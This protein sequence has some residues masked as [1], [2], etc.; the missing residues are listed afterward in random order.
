MNEKELKDLERLAKAAMEHNP[1]ESEDILEQALIER[2]DDLWRVIQKKARQRVN[3][4][5]AK[6][7]IASA[8]VVL[9][10]VMISGAVGVNQARAGKEGLLV[11]IVEGVAGKDIT[12][13]DEPVE[14]YS[15]TLE[16]GTWDDIMDN[17]DPVLIPLLPEDLPEEY[18][19]ESGSIDQPSLSDICM[20]L[21]YTNRNTNKLIQINYIYWSEDFKKEEFDLFSR[22]GTDQ[23]ESRQWDGIDVHTM[24]TNGIVNIAWE[25]D[26]CS[27]EIFGLESEEEGRTLFNAIQRE[28]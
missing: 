8:A 11:D 25:Q 20:S 1:K 12:F 26:A 7:W 14:F 13:S 3:M 19:F 17:I 22:I 28:P 23:Y 2:K 27:I 16:N 4:R 10:A 5:K 18:V 21:N 15:I 9:L 24:M 6:P